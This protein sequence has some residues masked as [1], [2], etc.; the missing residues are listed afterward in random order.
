MAEQDEGD[1]RVV[2][3]TLNQFCN[4]KTREQFVATVKPLI[5]TM[6]VVM[7]EAYTFANFHIIR[8]LSDP[9]FDVNELPKLDRNFYY[10]C[11]LAV[12]TSKARKNTLGADLEESV[13]AYDALRPEGYQK[14]DIRNYNQAVADISIQMAT[15]ACNSVWANID[16]IILRFLRTKHAHLKPHWNNIVKAVVTCPKTDLGK[17]FDLSVA[18][19]VEASVVA[20]LLRS[21][22]PLPSGQQFST[23]AHL[24]MRM[25]HTILGELLTESQQADTKPG[26]HSQVQTTVVQPITSQECVHHGVRSN[27]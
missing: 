12:S 16:R 15:M 23:R 19:A 24:A 18:L 17:L 25:F 7:A 1:I 22:L 5:I 3:M 27:L 20:A 9:T 21:W 8:C 2:K 13:E 26:M 10:R 4:D 6:N 11:I 14:A